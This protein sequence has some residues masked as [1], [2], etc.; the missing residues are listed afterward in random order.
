MVNDAL[1]LLLVPIGVVAGYLNVMA[2]GGSLLTVPA[3][4]FLGVPGHVANGTNRIAILAQNISAVT[5]FRHHGLH[6]FKLGLSLAACAIPGAIFGAWLGVQLQGIGFNR[7]LAAVMV[8]VMVVMAL[9]ERSKAKT[10]ARGNAIASQP[11]TRQRLIWGHVLM[12][13]AGVYGG[14][15]QIGVGF[16]LIAILHSVMRIDLVRVNMYKVFIV[17][18]YTVAALAVFASQLEL[19][20]VAGFFLAIGN[21]IGGWLGAKWSISQGERVI[22]WVLNTVLVMVIVKLLFFN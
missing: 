16:L 22:R 7:F 12:V 14:I 8:G 10:S 17:L 21:S 19:A 15:I 4:I 18:C 9:S 1:V 3:L 6:D 20:W 11:I 13:G 2:G 5:S